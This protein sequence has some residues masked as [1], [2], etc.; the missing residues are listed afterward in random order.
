MSD[1][2]H[3]PVRLDPAT[4]V[5]TGEGV[6]ESV[7]RVKDLA[8]VYAYEDTRASLDPEAVV[9]RVQAF[10]PVP[11]GQLGGV[12]CATTFLM[13]GSVGSEYFR[14]R[15]HFHANEDRP[16]LEVCISGQGAM[17]LMDRDR[18]T[19]TVPLGPGAVVHVPPG[20]AH[21]AVN[22]GAE[23]LV[24]V[25]YWASETGHDYQTIRDHGFSARLLAVDGRPTLV[26]QHPNAVHR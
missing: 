25:S 3:S 6:V 19:W 14:T 16:E 12:G 18:R 15:G 4:G 1:H 20:V 9:Y 26:P 8:G 17:L 21:C 23:T 11:E 22:T 7:R 24:F 10:E 2:T 13:A 5:L